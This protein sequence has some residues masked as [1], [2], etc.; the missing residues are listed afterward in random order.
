[1]ERMK[2]DCVE[3]RLRRRH[4]VHIGFL[5]A[6]AGR[7]RNENIFCPVQIL[8]GCWMADGALEAFAVTSTVVE[9]PMT[10]LVQQMS[11]PALR[12]SGTVFRNSHLH[13]FSYL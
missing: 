13:L 3:V 6:R 1:V 12:V 10:K 5:P 8:N 9:Q 4:C 7:L 2:S 11:E